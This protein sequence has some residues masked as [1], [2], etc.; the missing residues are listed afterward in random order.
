MSSTPVASF[1]R[2]ISA[3]ATM[4]PLGSLTVPLIEPLKLW[5]W[6][7]TGQSHAT[8]RRRVSAMTLMRMG[9][10]LVWYPDLAGRHRHP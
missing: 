1:F 9:D 3:P 7:G 4:A 6:P 8:A 10:S 5:D 2:T